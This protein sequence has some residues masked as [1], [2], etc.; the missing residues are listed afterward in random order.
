MHLNECVFAEPAHEG[1]VDLFIGVDNAGLHYSIADLRGEEGEPSARLGTLGWTCIGSPEGKK[2]T[3]ARACQSH[4]V[5][6]RA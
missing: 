3:G 6:Q 4:S 5:Y 1:L 2:W